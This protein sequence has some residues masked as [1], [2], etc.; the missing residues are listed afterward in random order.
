[1]THNVEAKINQE[2]FI[3]LM[4]LW[5]FKISTYYFNFTFAYSG[6]NSDE[7]KSKYDKIV[8]A[9]FFHKLDANHDRVG[10]CKFKS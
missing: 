10:C 3:V 4:S 6:A 8:A 2:W 1:M 7:D 5:I 9:S